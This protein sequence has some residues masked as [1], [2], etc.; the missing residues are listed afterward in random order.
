MKLHAKSRRANRV[1]L[2]L[3]ALA[4]GILLASMPATA[5]AYTDGDAP[6][7]SN[8]NYRF[9]EGDIDSAEVAQL[10]DPANTVL[11]GSFDLRDSIPI[12]V[13]DQGLL[14]LCDTFAITKCAETNYALTSGNAVDLSERYLDYMDSHKL[15][16]DDRQPGILP[17]EG[18]DG[19]F[20]EGDGTAYDEALALLETFGA[21]TEEQIPYANYTDEQIATMP[22][23]K[24]AVRVASSVAFPSVLFIEDEELKARW[25]D[26]IKTHIMKYG[27]VYSIVQEPVEGDTYNPA[28]SAFFSKEGETEPASGHAIS[29]V[30]WDDS[31]SK[32]N[33]LVQ[34]S[35][36]GAWIAVNSW[37]DEWGDG[38]FC[39]ISYEDDSLLLQ[40]AGVV[41]TEEPEAYRTY[42]NSAKLDVHEFFVAEEDKRFL[43]MS[44][45]TKGG[46]EWLSHLTVG[47]GG[48]AE[49]IFSSKVNVYLNPEDGTFDKAKLVLLEQTN[50]VAGSSKTNVSLNSPIPLTGDSFAL[51]FELIGDV[52]DF[53]LASARD[54]EGGFV[55][56]GMHYAESLDGQWTAHDEELPVF[57]FTL[58]D[59][60]VDDRID[61]IVPEDPAVPDDEEGS[62]GELTDPTVEGPEGEVP[63]PTVEGPEGEVLEPAEEEAEVYVPPEEST[64]ETSEETAVGELPEPTVEGSEGEVLDP[65]FEEAAAEPEP[66]EEN[67]TNKG[68]IQADDAGAKANSKLGAAQT[69][70]TGDSSKDTGASQKDASDASDAASKKA[71]APATTSVPVSTTSAKQ[72]RVATAAT[73]DGSP[74]QLAFAT[75]ALLFGLLLAGAARRTRA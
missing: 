3:C 46:A 56:G 67:G 60:E 73:G 38:G 14:G 13:N 69:G 30:G 72:A 41:A 63:G 15:Y 68:T 4:C 22:K 9:A 37:G 42:A 66:A 7:E 18:N 23:V 32:D 34:P 26:V 53:N 6:C 52:D 2:A 71:E 21:P 64:K 16:S 33:F 5:L 47:A 17:T 45:D 12:F 24:A 36:D 70:K 61:S 65:T 44:F 48:T 54:A 35:R 55:T 20:S 11:P 8:K 10:Y 29:I 31:Y 74:A 62:E 25:I 51:V 19:Y 50:S 75:T 57:V 27:S 28:T 49:D 39:Y 1:L 59:D 58:A 40:S 43:G